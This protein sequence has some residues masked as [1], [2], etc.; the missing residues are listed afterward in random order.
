MVS[1][2][3]VLPNNMF[4][5]ASY[6]YSIRIWNQNTFECINVLNGHTYAV[7]GLAIDQNEYLISISSDQSIIFWDILNNFSRL[8]TT[9]TAKPLYSLALFSNDSF[10]TGDSAGSIQMWSTSQFSFKND[11]TLKKHTDSVSDLVFLN[12][13]Y[14]VGTSFDKTIKIWDNSFNLW[15]STSNA[16]SKA[17]L[18]LKIKTKDHLVS[19]SQDGTI[20]FWKTDILILNK[21][22][23]I[24]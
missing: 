8:T 19:C 7:N 2:L 17:I 11:K 3:A 14:L 5:S 10:I 12:N 20:N 9:K 22:I 24:H 1:S 21:T 15:S 18:A 6:D 13:G 23:Y 16:H 4:A